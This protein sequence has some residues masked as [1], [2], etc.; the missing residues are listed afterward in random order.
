V[1]ELLAEARNSTRAVAD[2][3]EAQRDFWLAETDLQLAL[4]G[5]SPG[6]LQGLASAG[7]ATSTPQGH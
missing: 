5:T 3:I 7:T 2:A 1:W 6:P 4:T